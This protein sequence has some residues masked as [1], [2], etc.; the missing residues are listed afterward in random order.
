MG[1]IFLRVFRVQ[2]AGIE[3]DR[4]FDVL[5]FGRAVVRLVVIFHIGPGRF[6]EP[7]R[8]LLLQLFHFQNRLLFSSA[9]PEIPQ[10]RGFRRFFTRTAPI[11]KHIGRNSADAKSPEPPA[12]RADVT[13][14][15]HKSARAFSCS[16]SSQAPYSSFPPKETKTRSFRCSASPQRTRSA[17][18]RRGPHF[19]LSRSPRN[20]AKSALKAP[21][22]AGTLPC[23]QRGHTAPHRP[24]HGESCLLQG[25]ACC[26]RKIRQYSSGP[27][28]R[29]RY[30]ISP[31]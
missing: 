19:A 24:L 31:H 18:F 5:I 13:A 16:S 10:Q 6:A 25:T 12:L 26:G 11:A 23:P 28:T 8:V 21:S 22:G 14:R 1:Q 29:C 30:I 20:R 7:D 27:D 17:G 3:L 9:P 4:L 2:I 15:T